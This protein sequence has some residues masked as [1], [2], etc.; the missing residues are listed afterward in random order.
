MS[1]EERQAA[2]S[3]YLLVASQ[4]ETDGG[5]TED[6]DNHLERK[7]IL[8]SS[9]DGPPRLSA[10]PLVSNCKRVGLAFLR[11]A[12]FVCMT[13]ALLYIQLYLCSAYSYG[14]VPV[15]FVGTLNKTT[16]VSSIE[17]NC[18]V[19]EE[20]LDLWAQN[21]AKAKT[22]IAEVHPNVTN[23]PTMTWYSSEEVYRNR[24]GWIPL[25]S[26]GQ[27]LARPAIVKLDVDEGMTENQYLKLVEDAFLRNN[28]HF[29]AEDEDFQG[30][31][32]V[33]A[34]NGMLWN[35]VHGWIYYR[36]SLDWQFLMTVAFIILFV[37]C[38]T[39]MKFA[40][41]EANKDWRDACQV[42]IV[43]HDYLW[44]HGRKHLKTRS[45]SKSKSMPR[46]AKVAV[47]KDEPDEPKPK[48]PT[49]P[50]PEPEPVVVDIPWEEQ[51]MMCSPF[52]VLDNTIADAYKCEEEVY[53]ALA[54]AAMHSLCFSVCPVLS[55]LAMHFMEA[56]LPVFHVLMGAYALVLLPLGLS[57]YFSLNH[58]KTNL[59]FAIIQIVSLACW[60]L[61][62]IMYVVSCLIYLAAVAAI[63]PHLIT[64]ALV[65]LFTVFAYVTVTFTRLK[66]LQQHYIAVRE[67]TESP[68]FLM[69]QTRRLGFS[70]AAIILLCL[71]GVASLFGVF[72][73]QLA[74][75]NL[76][77]G[78]VH[79]RDDLLQAA[80]LPTF[81]LINAV[82]TT[83]NNFLNDANNY[84]APDIVTTIQDIF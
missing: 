68:G 32:L 6:E 76:Y 62:S 33:G 39:L 69:W 15:F 50:P 31:F 16:V 28:F 42:W 70:T 25:L 21:L 18:L 14:E 24:D 8:G 19:N 71:E 26:L 20:V 73:V 64:S 67:G 5:A 82:I 58:G 11:A 4:D 78:S 27:R 22:L 7:K 75:R 51:L 9:P 59:T 30:I 29:T 41:M 56:W 43:Q 57:Y 37:S 1:P 55:C 23:L 49:P 10:N 48:P 52:F 66:A 44:Q 60:M 80:I 77:A 38:A 79:R 81:A 83:K 2:A 47:T 84:I 34:A 36:P 40:V 54:S 46:P 12:I 45:S 13:S 63:D 65:P 35:S 3:S 53:W 72:M 74:M 61:S 17:E